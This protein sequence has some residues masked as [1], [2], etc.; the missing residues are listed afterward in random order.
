[1]TKP[2]LKWV[3]GKT[4]LLPEIHKHIP[5]YQQY[6]EPFVGGGAVF[7]SIGPNQSIISDANAELINAYRVVKDS[8]FELIEQLKSMPNTKE[9]YYRI[10]NIDR[11]VSFERLSDIERAAR[12]IYLN[13]FCFNGLWRVNKNNQMNVPYCGNKTRKIYYKPIL[14]CSE[15]LQTTQILH[16][17]FYDVIEFVTP[18]TFLY[19]DP[20]YVPISSTSDFTS[21]TKDG[22]D[23]D[24]QIRLVEFCDEVTKIGGRFLLSNSY[25][26]TTLELYQNYEIV[27][28]E[29]FRGV[30]SSNDSRKVVKE[31][32]VR[33]YP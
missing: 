9:D 10:R 6:I 21:Y 5:E 27:P 17:D 32:L 20:P 13:R 30:G 14:E 4:R 2:F 12:F 25:C 16:G 33:N 11:D 28:V 7:F 18:G 1:M 31:V 26:D 3:G 24:M 29:I 19:L 15:V 22:F 8:P 23:M